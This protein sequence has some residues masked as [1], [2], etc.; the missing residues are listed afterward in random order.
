MN[1]YIYDII[2]IGIG[3]FNLSFAALSHN[4][5]LK[6]IFFDKT[7]Y[8][9]WHRGV[10]IPRSTLQVPYL[11]DLVTPVEPTNPFSYLNYLV[12]TQNLLR[13]CIKETFYTTRKE[14]NDYCQWVAKQLPELK[15][16]S[17]VK[18]VQ[19]INDIEAYEVKVHNQTE[20]VTETYFTKKIVIGTGTVPAIPSFAEQ[21]TRERVFHSS[22]FMYREKYI[23]P[24]SNIT[25]I[26]SGQSSG[27]IFQ[28]L[29]HKSQEKLYKINWIT[30]DDRFFPMEDSKFTYEFTS[31]DF[32]DL[33][34][35]LPEDKRYELISR[36]DP[37]FKGMN[38]SLISDIF[39]ELYHMKMCEGVNPDVKIM[40]TTKLTSIKGDLDKGFDLEFYHL[41]EE[42]S[43]NVHTDYV[44]LATGY[45]YEDPVF[46]EGINDRINRDSRGNFVANRTFSIDKNGGEIYILNSEIASHGILTADLG[47]G[48]YRNATILNEILGK[49]HFKFEKKIAFQDFGIPKEFKQKN[50]RI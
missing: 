24:E 48:P 23:K 26:G 7:P 50:G 36:Q 44:I 8:F 42:E 43:F 2:G 5:P 22:Q 1:K 46:I 41:I 31:P 19:Y 33:F 18:S 29:L 15:F 27:E 14:Y 47:M 37:L 30:Q 13:Y 21:C 34:H 49:E 16:D 12:T 28:N 4:L 39:D 6:T 45:K 11:A 38:Q 32:I 9:D 10:M 20:K 40:P 35:S 3:P 17:N 25:I